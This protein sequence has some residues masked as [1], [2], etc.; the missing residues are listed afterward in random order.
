MFDEVEGQ[1][2]E[3]MIMRQFGRTPPGQSRLTGLQ[4]FWGAGSRLASE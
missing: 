2:K 4:T 3:M 1:E